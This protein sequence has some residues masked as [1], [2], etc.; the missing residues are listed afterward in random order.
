MSGCAGNLGATD[1]ERKNKN[2]PNQE[3]E[4]EDA[5]VIQV[6]VCKIFWN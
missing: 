3:K 2:K 5:E 1:K 6:W 4:E